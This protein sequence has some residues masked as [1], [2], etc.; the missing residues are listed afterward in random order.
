MSLSDAFRYHGGYG[1]YDRGSV[2][3]E[4]Y[5][6]SM[7]PPTPEISR[8]DNLQLILGS[9]SAAFGNLDRPG[10][11]GQALAQAGAVYQQQKAATLA[12]AFKRAQDEARQ[13][14][15]DEL[16]R[17]Q[18]EDR[19]AAQ[20]DRQYERDRQAKLDAQHEADRALGLKK[21]EDEARST[22]NTR[23][24]RVGRLIDAG[25]GAADAVNYAEDQNVTA[26]ALRQKEAEAAKAEQWRQVGS[27]G[28]A[29]VRVGPDGKMDIQ[30]IGAMPKPLTPEE[31][32]LK[33]QG[34]NP[35]DPAAVPLYMRSRG[36]E[37]KSG[38]IT[39]AGRL[40]LRENI[41]KKMVE[42]SIDPMDPTG[43]P[44]LDFATAMKRAA[45]IEQGITQEFDFN[46]P[47]P[48]LV[49]APIAGS[50]TPKPGTSSDANSAM[51]IIRTPRLGK[52]DDTDKASM[53][54]VLEAINRL[55][56]EKQSEALQL[57]WNEKL[58]N[59]KNK[60]WSMIWAEMQ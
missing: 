17:Q 28:G 21:I 43:K 25:Y 15:Q 32:F 53:N 33:E 18:M 7:L 42:D 59:G 6:R 57:V 3:P 38:G 19:T 44:K 58:P 41:A 12:D 49:H 30:R 35:A 16:F 51:T 52:M 14:R 47:P 50:E 20:A 24:A 5:G 23:Q 22:E 60:P 48:D 4:L 13:A 1:G 39:D 27:E 46:E 29:F 8:H 11:L 37:K 45:P 34:F 54:K 40:R 55:P 2:A 9:L 36:L 56:K 26:D 31:N 10:R